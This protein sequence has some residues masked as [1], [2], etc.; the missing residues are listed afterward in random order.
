MLSPAEKQARAM[1]GGRQ[2]LTAWQ[3]NPAVGA[4]HH[5]LGA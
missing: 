2:G 1:F 3:V 5:V 4:G